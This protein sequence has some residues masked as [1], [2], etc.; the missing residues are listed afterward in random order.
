MEALHRIT[1]EYVDLED[2]IRV[3]GETEAGERLV[4]WLTRRLLDR[5]VQHLAGWLEKRDTHQAPE[6]AMSRLYDEARQGF[7]QE[8][9]RA[10][11]KPEPPVPA[12]AARRSWLVGAVDINARE[13]MVTL[14]FRGS[15][16]SENVR[17]AL[18][19]AHLRQWLEIVRELYLRGDWP[20]TPWPGWMTPSA[21]PA[22]GPLRLMH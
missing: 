8:A 9:A 22:N 4:L 1:C 3:A 16:P 13:E 7:A 12:A 15:G 17:L 5:L 6:Q 18:S 20:L 2:R 19:E 14:D 11:L 21:D 10:G